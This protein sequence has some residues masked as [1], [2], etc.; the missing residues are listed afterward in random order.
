MEGISQRE[1]GLAY[2]K[3]ETAE[4]MIEIGDEMNTCPRYMS[5]A[6]FIYLF[7]FVVFTNSA[8]A[9]TPPEIARSAFTSTVLLVL[10]DTDGQSISLGS[11]FFVRQGEIVTNLHVIAGA[12]RGY[13]KLIGKQEKYDIQGYTVVDTERDLVILKVESNAKALQIGD[14]KL[15]EVG[16]TVFAVGNPKGLEGTFSQGIV[17]GIRD[18]DNEQLLQITA[19]I[20]PGSSGGPVLNSKGEVIGVSVATFKGGQ[21]LNFAIPSCYLTELLKGDPSDKPI[22]LSRLS[23]SRNSVLKD[24][25]TK[26]TSGVTGSQLMWQYEYIVSAASRFSFSV[27]NQLRNDISE[28][29]CLIIFRDENS[30]PI[31]SKIVTYKTVVP[32]GLAKRVNDQVDTSIQA[33]TTKEGSRIPITGRVE[34][35]ILDFKVEE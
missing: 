5:S 25:G 26:I 22:E 19:P 31:E 30:L 13:V 33:L 7:F 8:S 10:E 18:I 32:A 20:S 1:N 27:R 3:F 34:F 24:K 28:I 11:G 14:S 35:R 12:S 17:S 29:T 4:V 21:N 15:T 23:R 2:S 9:Q 16:E 6:H